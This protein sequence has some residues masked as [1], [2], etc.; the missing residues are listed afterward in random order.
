MGETKHFTLTIAEVHRGKAAWDK[1]IAAN[2]FND[3]P[4]AGMEYLLL[5]VKVDYVEGPA[6]EALTLD[7]WDFRIVSKGQ[8]LEPVA[9]VEPEP[10]FDVSF[11]PGASG[12]GWMAW[13]VYVDDPDPLLAIGLDYAGRGASISPRTSKPG[14]LPVWLPAA[15]L[16]VAFPATLGG[17]G[18]RPWPMPGRCLHPEVNVN[19]KRLPGDVF[20]NG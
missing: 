2:Q 12:G 20:V 6:D 17:C 18:A 15:L 9:V 7:Q 5:S 10:E 8:I 16:C 1:I 13:P 4:A 3:P 11:F 14:G 19:Q